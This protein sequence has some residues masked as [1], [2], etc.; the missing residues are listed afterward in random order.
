MFPMKQYLFLL[1]LLTP[2]MQA[3]VTYNVTADFSLTNNPNGAWSYL[4]ASVLLTLQ[5]PL[6]NGNPVIPA[7]ANGFWGVGNNLDVHTPTLTLA[8]VNAGSAGGNTTL[9]FAAG[10]LLGHSPNAGE[11]LIIRWTA[12]AA[13]TI[14]SYSG[15][16]WYAHS[17]V[18]RSSDWSLLL[19]GS[20]LTSGVIG[21]SNDRTNASTFGGGAL[22][23]A[24]GD[25]F[26]FAIA[27]SNGQQF[28]SL[29][30]LTLELDFTADTQVPE[31]HTLGLAALGLLLAGVR[32][33]RR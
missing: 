29:F 32:Q 3:G 18:V 5:T 25:L 12:P 7:F 16:V 21:T 13:G 14:D 22:S 10:E 30:G 27:K 24:A 6:N 11:A 28:G 2:A 9:D 33:L 23:V 19:N 17:T 4:D 20:P 15:S 26:E 1:S 31:P 8:A